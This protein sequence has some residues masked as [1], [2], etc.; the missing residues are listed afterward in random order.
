MNIKRIMAAALSVLVIGG[1]MPVVQLTAPMMTSYA[2]EATEVTEGALTFNVYADHAEVTKCAYSA[3]GDIVFPGEINGM[4]VTIINERAFANC[5]KISS[6][7]IPDSI[8]KIGQSA[9]SYCRSLKSVTI[10]SSVLSIGSEAFGGCESLESISVDNANQY[11]LSE[12]GVLFDHDK[13][14]LIVYPANKSETS[15][16]IPDS[17]TTIEKGAFYHSQNLVSVTMAEGLSAIETEAFML[18][19][20]E[21]VTLPLSV[22]HIGQSAFAICWRLKELTILNDSCYICD[23]CQTIFNDF[24]E[25][26][27]ETRT[28]TLRGYEGSTAQEYAE[29]YGIKFEIA[30]DSERGYSKVVEGALTYYVY[31][32]HAELI[33]CDTSAEGEIVIADKVNGVPVTVIR[34]CAF[35]SRNSLV[36]VTIPETVSSIG[37][38]AFESCNLTDIV[39]PAS[40]SSIG[41]NAFCLCRDLVRIVFMNPDCIIP[42]EGRAAVC[43]SYFEDEKIGYSGIIVGYE[44]STAQE[45]A[46]RHGMAF[47]TIGNEKTQ[48]LTE[49]WLSY[50]VTP[51]EVIVMKCDYEAEGDIVIPEKISGVPVTEIAENAFADHAGITSVTLPDTVEKIGDRAFTNCENLSSIKMSASLKEVGDCGFSVCFSLVSVDLP[52][53][54]TKIG[55]SAF[56][57]CVNLESMTIHNPE[58][59]IFDSRYTIINGY[60]Y[61]YGDYNFNGTIYGYEGSTAQAF[62]EKYGYNFEVLGETSDTNHK[63]GD[64]DGDGVIDSTDASSVLAEYAAIQTGAAPAV[65]TSVGDVN[66]DGFI[67]ASDASDILQFYTYIQTGGTDSLSE[68]LRTR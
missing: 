13:K 66:G 39:I 21:S 8:T 11:Y 50:R 41:N 15:Y 20:I 14:T 49:G 2:E 27:A 28:L 60:N 38:S 42:E 9:F 44:G 32:D 29:K 26:L 47:E 52:D 18:S 65:S 48:F 35:L 34:E 63:L 51:D 45:Y 64:L 10:P 31:P 57:Y 68:F 3:E 46:Q 16:A 4:P 36:S 30:D 17:V 43:N 59:E 67:D 56:G 5:E 25:D 40:V 12:N 6:V 54:V 37:Y 19:G 33:E 55:E 7:V 23:G 24:T 53:S 61:E 1:T 58:C 62:A 22:S